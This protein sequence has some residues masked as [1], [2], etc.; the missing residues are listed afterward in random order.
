MRRRAANI[1]A[2]SNGAF[3]NHLVIDGCLAGSWSRTLKATLGADRGCA[4][5]EADARADPGRR[6]RRR[7]LRRIPR[8]ARHIVDRV[9]LQGLSRPQVL[10]RPIIAISRVQPLFGGRLVVAERQPPPQAPASIR[11]RRTIP[12]RSRRLPGRPMRPSR[13]SASPSTSSPSPKAC[14]I[15]GAWRSCRRQDAGHRASRPAARRRHG[16]QAVGAGHRTAGGVRARAGRTA[17]RR[18]RSGVREEQPDLLE[19]LGAAREQREQHRGGARQ[20]RRRCGGAAR[21]RRAGDLSP[22]AVDEFDHCTSAAAWC[23]AA[24]A[25]CS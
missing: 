25:R 18:A 11:G 19:L 15:R 3:A 13:S 22:D 23:S 5:Q 20:V 6:Q 2:R 7:M 10:R 24:T 1:V 17:R 12:N 16:R 9:E 4:V 21:R 14:R 8:P